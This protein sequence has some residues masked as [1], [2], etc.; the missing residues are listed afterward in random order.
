MALRTSSPWT[1]DAP[2]VSL[3]KDRPAPPPV[4]FGDMVGTFERLTANLSR[5]LAELERSVAAQK[6]AQKEAQEPVEPSANPVRGWLAKRQ[7]MAEAVTFVRERTNA[8]TPPTAKEVG[9]RFVMSES[10]GRDRIKDAVAQ[11]SPNGKVLTPQS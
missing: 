6:E 4:T 1:P 3:V 8:G 5:R 9:L 7:Q 2:R 10:W 11:E